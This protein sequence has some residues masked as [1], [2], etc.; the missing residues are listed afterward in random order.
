MLSV[1]S[2]LKGYI[3]YFSI[4]ITSWKWQSYITGEDFEK[5]LSI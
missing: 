4:N 3:L 5:D 2:K 1:E